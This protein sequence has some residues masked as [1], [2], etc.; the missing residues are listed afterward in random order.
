MSEYRELP[1]EALNSVELHGAV[2]RHVWFRWPKP[3]EQ[4]SECYSCPYAVAFDVYELQ[5]FPGE[6]VAIRRKEQDRHYP[7]FCAKSDGKGGFGPK[8]RGRP[9]KKP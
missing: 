1:I 6:L 2:F 9:K 3:D 7:N 5:P 8:R 4:S